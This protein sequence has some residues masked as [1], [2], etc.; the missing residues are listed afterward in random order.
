MPDANVFRV[1]YQSMEAGQA[2]LKAT[3]FAL[4]EHAANYKKA[5]DRASATWR[6]QTHEQIN[7]HH[8][9]IQQIIA[10][11]NNRRMMT[12]NTVGNISEET[13]ATDLYSARQVSIT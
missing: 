10:G 13:Q 12:H 11:M 9:Q 1:Q 2:R 7:F 4:A 6:G 5:I 8:N 3:T